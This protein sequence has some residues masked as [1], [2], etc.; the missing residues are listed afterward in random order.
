MR[1]LAG[2]NYFASGKQVVIDCHVA[3]RYSTALQVH[4]QRTDPAIVVSTNSI[5]MK[6]RAVTL[7]TIERHLNSMLDT[8]ALLTPLVDSFVQSA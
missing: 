4:L 7:D 6:G 2:I 1:K 3:R 5:R 8:P